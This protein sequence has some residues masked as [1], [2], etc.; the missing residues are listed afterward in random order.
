[1]EG[2]WHAKQTTLFFFSR[3]CTINT[4]SNFSQKIPFF[5]FF[6]WSRFVWL[7]VLVVVVFWFCEDHLAHFQLFAVI[8]I[9]CIACTQSMVKQTTKTRFFASLFSNIAKI[10]LASFL[11][12]K[13]TKSKTNTNDRR[14]EGK[15]RGWHDCMIH[16]ASNDGYWGGQGVKAERVRFFFFSG[17]KAS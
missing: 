9:H 3:T 2:R 7:L 10:F 1:M 11:V 6:F 12:N 14:T 16:F 8:H 4:S 17:A 15:D 5:P 13:E